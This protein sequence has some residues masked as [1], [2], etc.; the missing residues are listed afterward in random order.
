[1]SAGRGEDRGGDSGGHPRVAGDL[2]DF[3][4]DVFVEGLEKDSF[5]RTCLV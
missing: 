4:P 5:C 1:M 2:E 3:Y